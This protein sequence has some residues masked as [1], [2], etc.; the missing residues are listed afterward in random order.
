MLAENLIDIMKMAVEYILLAIFFVC[1]ID[2]VHV[3]DR[4]AETLN[5][6][7]DL[8]VTTRQQLEFGKYNTG[9]NQTNPDECL[10]AD[11][12]MEA[13]R[14]YRDAGVCIYVDRMGRNG[15]VRYDYLLD[16]TTLEEYQRNGWLSVDYLKKT[17][18]LENARYHPYVVFDNDDMKGPYHNTGTEVKGIAFILL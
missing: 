9:L 1:V 16:G 3:K 5:R 12:V 11:A 18:D 15:Y 13:V 10:N 4:Y 14:L 2:F 8:Q 17:L 7:Y 6:E